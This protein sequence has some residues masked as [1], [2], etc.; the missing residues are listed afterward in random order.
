M[1]WTYHES[2]AIKPTKILVAMSGGVDSSVAAAMLVEQGHDVVGCFM[3]LGTPG[4]DLEA[5]RSDAGEQLRIAHRGCCSIGDAADARRV[6]A[7]LGIPF[8]VCNFKREFGRIIDYFVGDYNDGRTPNPCIRC[9]DWLKFG[10]LHEY[11]QQID[12]THLASGHYARVEHGPSG[13]RLLRG[14]D[15]DKDQSYVLFGAP[16]DRISQMLLPIGGLTKA[17]V[18]EKARQFGLMTA[19]KPESQEICFVPDDDYAGL[20]ERRSPGSIVQGEILDEEGKIIGEH[21]GHQH[22]TVGQRRGIGI[23]TG[24]PLYVLSKDPSSNSITIGKSDRLDVASCTCGEINWLESEPRREDA[25]ECEV[26]FR[27]HATPVRARVH[28]EGRRLHVVFLEPQKAVAPGQA[29]VCYEGDVVLGGGWIESVSV[30]E[31]PCSE[32]TPDAIIN[33]EAI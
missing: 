7:R 2:M 27:A 25:L 32:K 19:E 30:D 31:P 33:N 5:D 13:S 8:Y 26:Q 23:A 29:L 21:P 4:E 16:A 24:I 28:M 12:A 14:I 3:R 10:R 11:A 17:E 20:I 18:R 22:F 9:N 15:H 1:P 6:A